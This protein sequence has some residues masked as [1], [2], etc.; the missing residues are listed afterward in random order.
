MALNK[1]YNYQSAA[2]QAENL[3]QSI[4][5]KSGAVIRVAITPRT[6][7]ELPAS[8]TPEEIEMW[9]ANY[10]KLHASKI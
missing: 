6:M 9:V 5:D 2:D 7:I 1:G 10:K 3:L 8:L 4:K